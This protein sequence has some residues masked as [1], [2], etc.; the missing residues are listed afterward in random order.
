[1]A[2]GGWYDWFYEESATIIPAFAVGYFLPGPGIVYGA[3]Y[4]AGFDVVYGTGRGGFDLNRIATQGAVGGAAA[5]GGSLL[6]MR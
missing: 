6:R 4:G 5:L 2:Y 1:M 3:V